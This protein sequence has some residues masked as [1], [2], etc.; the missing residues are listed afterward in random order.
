MTEDSELVERAQAG[1][2]AAFS[3]LVGR[4]RDAACGVAYH[5]LG[6]FE[7]VQDAVQ[8]AFVSAYLNLR[9]LRETG[10]FGPWLRRIT[11]N[12]CAMLL[13]KRGDRL[14]STEEVG[15]EVAMNSSSSAEADSERLAAQIV[16]RDALSR[17]PEATRLV[18]TLFYINGYSHAEIA[19]FLEVPVNTVR[20]RLQRAKKQLREEMITMVKDVLTEGKPDEEF[21]KKIEEVIR[22]GDEAQKAHAT[23]DALRYYDEALTTLGQLAPDES[24]KRLQFDALSKKAEASLFSLGVGSEERMKLY[25][26]ALKI[27]E[28]LGDHRA[29]ADSLVRIGRMYYGTEPEETAWNYFEKAL[30]LYE[31][32]DDKRGQGESLSLLGGL[33]MRSGEIEE[34]RSMI[35]KALRLFEVAHDLNMVAGCQAAIDDLAEVGNE[36]IR[37][38][39][40]AVKGKRRAHSLISY[41]STCVVLEKKDGVIEFVSQFGGGPGA[42]SGGGDIPKAFS[43]SS[44][45]YQI[46]NLRKFSDASVP[47]GESWSGDSFSYTLRPLKTTVSIKSAS[48]Q[49]VV[50]AGDFAEC[51]LTEITTQGNEQPDTSSELNTMLDRMLLIGTRRA[52]YA[53]GVGLVQLHVRIGDDTEA[54]IQLREYHI[55]E[56]SDDY[57][58]LAIGNSWTYGWANVPPEYVNK[59]Y[60]RV[61]A[62]EGEKWYLE[63]YGYVYKEPD[64]T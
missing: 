64:K 19:D 23:E 15:E 18:T 43:I 16:V 30:H 33:R 2:V 13:R 37:E 58:P 61:M 9:Q 39:Y 11:A 48:E 10:K 50:P 8:E 7:D 53:P 54:L 57:L 31:E 60:Y 59:E 36:R 62:N 35:E 20:S 24:L 49:V 52:W 44:I 56:G 63:E 4:Y 21:T 42:W 41:R 28:E 51:L 22:K 32:L 6:N 1:E 45:F 3:E 5:Y 27:A 40:E 29:Q 38:Y 12:A 25:Q 46:S 17:L 47:V 26:Q 14:I 55:E 34:G